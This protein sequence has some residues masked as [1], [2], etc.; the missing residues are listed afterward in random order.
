[1]NRHLDLVIG[2]LIAIMFA[3]MLRVVLPYA[4]LADIRPPKG[5]KPYTDEQLR[6]RAVYIREGCIYCHT[7][8]P[9]DPGQTP[10]DGARGWGR[11]SVPADYVHDRP[12]LLG[13]MRT[14][15]DLFNIGARQPSQEWHLVHLY[16]PRAV[17]PG[18]IMP[19]YPYL[20][21]HSR[22]PAGQVEVNVP[23]K[24]RIT[25]AG[26]IV[27]TRDALDLVAYLKGLDHTYP[28]RVD[29]AES[30]TTGSPK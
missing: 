28:I 11:P 4:Q 27:A 6:G 24:F 26:P 13:T 23:E 7:Q 14:G 18:S 30:Q 25:G 21:R 29:E 20:F 10:A 19:A 17:V 12:P 3:T 5:L 9:R 8:Q 2:V 22:E 16:Q 1:M 15:P